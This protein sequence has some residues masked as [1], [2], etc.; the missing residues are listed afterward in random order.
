MAIF[1]VFGAVPLFAIGLTLRSQD[2]STAGLGGEHG[3][4]S[5]ATDKPDKS[6]T[7]SGSSE[8]TSVYHEEHKPRLLLMG[9]KR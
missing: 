7:R 3:R 4:D 8:T 1:V 9:L 2:L 6:S 5:K